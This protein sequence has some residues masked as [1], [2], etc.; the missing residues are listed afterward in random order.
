[1]I[2]SLGGWQAIQAPAQDR[3]A[4]RI[5]VKDARLNVDAR[6]VALQWLLDEIASQ[7]G[8][9]IHG[10]GLLRGLTVS[11]RLDNVPVDDGLKELLSAFDVFFLYAPSGHQPASLRAVWVHPRGRGALLAPVS[12]E[13]WA[14]TIE[15]ERGTADPDPEVRALAVESLVERLGERALGK[16]LEALQDTDDYVRERAL[17]ATIDAGLELPVEDLRHLAT[18]DSDPEVRRLALR[19]FAD[20]S[21]VLDADVTTL[22]EAAR[23]DPSPVV[24][25]EA[26][27]ILK[28]RERASKASRAPQQRP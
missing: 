26:G 10:T 13:Q 12:P 9:T 22:L 11:T 3:P 4:P 20:H 21:D 6:D 1:M 16:V 5:A 15:L 7:A 23:L 25:R 27:E 24:Q 18:A 17:D 2:A 8:L 19:T 14:S 28:S